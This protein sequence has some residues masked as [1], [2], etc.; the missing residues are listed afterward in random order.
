M[1]LNMINNYK[2]II[3]LNKIE[4]NSALSQLNQGLI[5][6]LTKTESNSKSTI[7][8]ATKESNVK[9]SLKILSASL[10]A[11][12]GN[13]EE[14]NTLFGEERNIVLNDFKLNSLIKD[15]KPKNIK[16]ANEGDFVLYKNDFT[17][18]DFDFS[19]SVIGGK[20]NSTLNSNFKNFMKDINGWDKGTEKGFKIAYHYLQFANSLTQNNVFLKMNNA[21][22]LVNKSNF[23]INSSELQSLTYTH[24]KICIFGIVEAIMTKNANEVNKEISE[25]FDEDEQN[26]AIVANIGKFV[27]L[28]TEITLLSAGL[29][30]KDDRFI[31]PIALY[32]D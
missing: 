10:K 11:N 9:G 5:E 16:N 31:R 18:S 6:S 17:I 27:P 28:L 20:N 7:E 3:Y 25:L 22:S 14:L 21:A 4:L 19:A 2:E 30:K 13:S 12:D 24:R 1:I 26:E 15:S 32:F 8:S 23:R 29:I